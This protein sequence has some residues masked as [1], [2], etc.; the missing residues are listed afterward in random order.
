M[1]F[2]LYI[3]TSELR[4]PLESRAD[5]MFITDEFTDLSCII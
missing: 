5:E 4:T 1:T 2:L 3:K